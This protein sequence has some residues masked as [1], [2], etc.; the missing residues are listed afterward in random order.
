M[1]EIEGIVPVAPT[2]FDNDGRIDEKGLRRLID[3]CVKGATPA[4]FACPP[5][6]A[7]FTNSP[8]RNGT[9]W[10]ESLLT[11]RPGAFL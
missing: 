11:K 2:P 7:S 10:C 5:T 8:S 6:Q 3:F 9:M 4:P 1:I